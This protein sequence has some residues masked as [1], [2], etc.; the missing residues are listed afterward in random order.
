MSRR[1]DGTKLFEVW[2]KSII[3]FKTLL[4]TVISVMQEYIVNRDIVRND[5][6]TITRL[7]QLYDKHGVLVIKN[8][9]TPEAFASAAAHA[10]AAWMTDVAPQLPVDVPKPKADVNIFDIARQ[11]KYWK[12]GTIGNKS[13][14]Y[15]FAQPEEK[16]KSV[17]VQLSRNLKVYM[18][19][20][21]GY[22]AN[23][24]LVCHQ[25]SEEM[26]DILM[27]VTGNEH[28]MISQ[29]SCKIHRESLTEPHADVYHPNEH[30]INRSQAIAFGPNEGAVR[31]CFAVGSHTVD[32]K[33]KI[34]NAIDRDI[35]KT[36][37]FQK[38]P[39]DKR[40][41]LYKIIGESVYCG[42]RYDIVIW[43]PTIIHFEALK[44]E[45]GLAFRTD[46]STTV[47]RYIIGTQTPVELSQQQLKEI[48]FYAQN[49]WIW[50]P[51]NNLNKN[52][53][54][55]TNSV[56]LKRTQYKRPREQTTDEKERFASAQSRL[57]RMQH[58]QPAKNDM[59]GLD[60]FIDNLGTS[61]KR[62]YGIL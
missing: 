47:E 58:T 51:Y 17:S 52:T 32:M 36:S 29:D 16:D 35:Y 50:H 44:T 26:L 1:Y 5:L 42:D 10:R 62:A 6:E 45:K 31:L 3:F 22:Q 53:A 41:A 23:L 33:K 14:G 49:G 43:K 46:K 7:K 54:I 11:D 12:A 39:A 56:H 28:G 59:D 15:L 19:M 13:F 2:Y 8:G 34:T 30:K 21:S 20:G 38:V 60:Q 61:R 18:A 40:K 37:G 9:F 48:A 24:A 57:K 55:G 4:F 27:K 25:T